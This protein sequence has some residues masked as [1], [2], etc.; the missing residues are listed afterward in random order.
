MGKGENCVLCVCM[1]LCDWLGVELCILQ[2]V[3]V[4]YSKALKEQL[5]Y[6]LVTSSAK[7]VFMH[8]IQ[9]SS[10]GYLNWAHERLQTA[11]SHF[12]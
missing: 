4:P 2:E 12:R 8:I 1:G 9:R 6:A 7:Q 5:D 10:A 3:K 11:R